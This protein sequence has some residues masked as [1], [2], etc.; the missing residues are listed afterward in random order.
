MKVKKNQAAELQGT[1]QDE[2]EAFVKDVPSSQPLSWIHYKK[3]A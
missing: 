1:A 2:M 3:R